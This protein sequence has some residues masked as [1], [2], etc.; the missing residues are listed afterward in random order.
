VRDADAP[1]TAL[2]CDGIAC[3][4]FIWRFLVDDLWPRFNVVHWNYRGHGRSQAPK[5]ETRV[6]TRAFVDDL[7]CVRAS[8]V[9]TDVVL[10]GHSMGC[11]IALEG[12]RRNPR[13]VA[14]M[15][16]M[17]GT[18]GRMTHT[19]KGKDA[20]ARALPGLIER[21]E[22]NPRFARALWSN[23]P[24]AMAARVALATGEVDAV[25][26]PEDLMKYSDHVANLD[27][28]M[29]LRMLRA[30]GDESAAEMLGSVTAPVLVIAGEQDSFTPAHLAEEMARALPH[31]ELMMCPGATHVAPIERRDDVRDRIEAFAR[32]HID[33]D[34][35]MVGTGVR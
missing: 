25:V 11:Q 13:G 18:A 19:F 17:C 26:D 4:G 30:M 7:E 22:K 33:G 16:L 14:A 6:D 9:S 21:V 2:L 1:V 12:Y 27:L 20:L 5:D 10:F 24:P 15:V 32:E 31:G 3:D 35:S 8:C 23:V 28:L 34:S 29:F